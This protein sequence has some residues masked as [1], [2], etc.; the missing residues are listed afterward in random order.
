MRF[1]VPVEVDISDNWVIL[2]WRDLLNITEIIRNYKNFLILTFLVMLLL[3][4]LA[5]AKVKPICL[6]I[7]SSP[8][9]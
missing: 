2:F 9:Y 7:P 1:G 6:K 4:L 5:I 8:L 3:L